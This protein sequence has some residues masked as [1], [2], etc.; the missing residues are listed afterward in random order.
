MTVKARFDGI[1][2]LSGEKEAGHA[3]GAKTFVCELF[4]DDR[5][6]I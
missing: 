2:Q 3:V 4:C 5:R 1:F 6:C